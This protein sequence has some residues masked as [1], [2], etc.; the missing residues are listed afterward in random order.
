MYT[1]ACSSSLDLEDITTNE[2][3]ILIATRF[4]GGGGWI[5]WRKEGQRNSYSLYFIT[6]GDQNNII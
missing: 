6:F 4:I 1:C 3:Y 5:N 2:G